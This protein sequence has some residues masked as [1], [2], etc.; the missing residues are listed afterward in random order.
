VQ[1][2]EEVE[3]L[4]VVDRGDTQFFSGEFFLFHDPRSQQLTIEWFDK[5]PA[6]LQIVG[7]IVQCALPMTETMRPVK[8]GFLEDDD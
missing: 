1:C 5:R 8:T 2:K 6:H 7:L 4:V 3:M